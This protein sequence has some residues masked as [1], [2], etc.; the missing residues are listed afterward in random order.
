MGLQPL[1]ILLSSGV[2]TPTVLLTVTLHQLARPGIASWNVT[3]RP[4]H[5]APTL[6]VL[7]HPPQRPVD[8]EPESPPFPAMPHC[9]AKHHEGAT[10]SHPGTTPLPPAARGIMLNRGVKRP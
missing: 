8:T 2:G 10:P 5:E 7:H 1:L 4:Q 9:H 6:T 3:M